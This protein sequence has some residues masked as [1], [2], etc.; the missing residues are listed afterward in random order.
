MN[1]LPWEFLHPERASWSESLVTIVTNELE[2][3]DKATDVAFFRPDYTSLSDLQKVRVWCE[4]FVWLA[5]HESN[6][7]PA[8]NSVDAGTREDKDTYSVGLLQVSVCDQKNRRLPFAYS[9]EDL[10]QVTPN[11]TLGIAIL[12]DQIHKKG[13]IMIHHGQSGDYW[14][15]LCPGGK[16]DASAL[17]AQKTKSLI[18]PPA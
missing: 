3:L 16:Y 12:C 4:F 14:S 6:W 17:I 15:T 8:V 2:N 10:Q 9:F 18:F 13:V 5:A 11:L 7:N 1:N